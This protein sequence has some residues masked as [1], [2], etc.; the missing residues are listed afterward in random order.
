MEQ[1]YKY[2]V[3]TRCFTFNQSAY[4]LEALNGFA[5]QETTFPVVTL[6]VDDAS[7]DGEQNV[8]R[9][10]LEKCFQEPF[11][12]EETEYAHI[13]CAHHKTNLNCEFVVFL[14]KYNHY[15]IKKP[16]LPY[17]SEWLENA[18]YHAICEGD[19]Y[20]KS[21][22]KLQMQVDFLE[23]HQDY[24]M[25]HTDFDLSNGA[26][27]N[28]SVVQMPDDNYFPDIIFKGQ[29]IGTATTLYLKEAYQ[30]IPKLYQGKSWPMSDLPMWIEMSKEGK[31]KFFPTVTTCYRVSDDSASHGSLEKE[32]LFLKTSVEIRMY[33]ANHYGLE[34]PYNGYGKGYYST[35]M[36]CAYKHKSKKIAKECFINAFHSNM[37]S[38]K[39]IVFMG[40]TYIP[41]LDRIIRLIWR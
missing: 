41:L 27:R 22:R 33:Y 4:I 18:K 21:P 34:L 32:L 13:I 37:I 1:E 17:L 38:V 39:T 15:S 12:T 20:W 29:Q 16:N 9:Q 8:I 25:C 2:I 24:V 26:K 30:R 23:N 10:Y 40:A 31:I 7:T 6:I 35:V 19:D 28:H 11:R 36:K 3:C 5:M 14:L